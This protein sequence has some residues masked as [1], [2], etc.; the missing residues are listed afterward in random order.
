MSSLVSYNADTT[1]LLRIK[2]VLSLVRN[3]LIVMLQRWIPLHIFANIINDT[4]SLI[5]QLH[6]STQCFIGNTNPLFRTQSNKVKL[7]AITECNI[8]VPKFLKIL[9]EKGLKPSLTW[10]LIRFSSLWSQLMI[11][12]KY[13]LNTTTRI[14]SNLGTR[15]MI[16][17]SFHREAESADI[18][19]NLTTEY[20]Q[21]KLRW[22]VYF[23]TR[24]DKGKSVTSNLILIT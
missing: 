24:K 1:I 5:W 18:T 6:I 13:S 7:L 21:L 11:T 2:N 16:I 10:G 8:D 14:H 19:F 4:P 15:S 20:L 12:A 22:D 3:A 23:L 9:R 17:R